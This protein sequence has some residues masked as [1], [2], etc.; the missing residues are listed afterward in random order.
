MQ[1]GGGRRYLPTRTSDSAGTVAT[2]TRHT[3][4]M[5]INGTTAVQ[6]VPRLSLNWRCRRC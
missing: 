2:I 1:G 4:L 3:A 6:R 5:A